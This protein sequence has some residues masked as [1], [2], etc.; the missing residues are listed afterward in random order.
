MSSK[1]RKKQ[2]VDVYTSNPIGPTTTKL[3][4]RGMKV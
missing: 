2:L 1:E 3:I 4:A